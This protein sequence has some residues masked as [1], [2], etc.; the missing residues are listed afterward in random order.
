M[1]K[2]KKSVTKSSREDEGQ[3]V[4]LGKLKVVARR[5][6]IGKFRAGEVSLE[7]AVVSPNVWTD[8]VR[9]T[10]PSE[11][12]LAAVVKSARATGIKGKSSGKSGKKG[13][14]GAAAAPTLAVDEATVVAAVMMK[15]EFKRDAAERQQLVEQKRK[16][17]I[18]YICTHFNGGAKEGALPRLRVELGLAQLKRVNFQAE[19]GPSVRTLAEQCAV[20]LREEAHIPLVRVEVPEDQLGADD[21]KGGGKGRRGHGRGGG[22]LAKGRGKGRGGRAG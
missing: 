14:A 4:S 12:Q 16:Q 21:A 22:G 9:G 10:R 2:S 6:M 17:V 11:A 7:E 5:G 1:P 20:R 19:G 8:P 13:K 15:G 18:T 3:I